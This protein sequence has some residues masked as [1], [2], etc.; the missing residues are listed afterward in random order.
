M[1]DAANEYAKALIDDVA[2]NLS[3]GDAMALVRFA[4]GPQ[5][6]VEA[7]EVLEDR[8]SPLVT[9]RA[10][11]GTVWRTS[12]DRLECVRYIPKPL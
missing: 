12:L 3:R 4:G 9:V 2:F 6:G 10:A 8:K 5:E 7:V 11:D 1:T